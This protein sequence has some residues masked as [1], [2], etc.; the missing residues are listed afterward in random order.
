MELVGMKTWILAGAIALAAMGMV[1]LD[2]GVAKAGNLET[3]TVTEVN[4]G[5]IKNLLKLTAAQEPLWARVEGVLLSIAREQAQEGFLRRISRRVVSIAFNSAVSERVKSAAL[6]LLAS[7][8]E[9]QK[10]TVRR[11]AQQMGIGDTAAA[12]N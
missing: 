1:L 11:L 5:K 8:D 3:N 12:A 4:V 9:E 2:R 6:P 10:A 7:L